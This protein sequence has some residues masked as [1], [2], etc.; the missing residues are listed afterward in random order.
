MRKQPPRKQASK[1]KQVQ[2]RDPYNF[3][4]RACTVNQIIQQYH[5]LVSWKPTCRHNSRA[6]LECKL[7]VISVYCLQ[8]D[9][10]N[11]VNEFRVYESTPYNCKNNLVENWLNFLR[12]YYFWLVGQGNKDAQLRLIQQGI[13]EIQD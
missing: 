10:E 8:Q 7:L 11:H 5:F 13:S 2:E 1:N 12:S 6:F 3:F 4:P 9:V